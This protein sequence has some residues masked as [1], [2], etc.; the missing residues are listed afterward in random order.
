MNTSKEERSRKVEKTFSKKF[1]K[2][3]DKPPQ[4]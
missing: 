4:M 3:L 2:T 1:E